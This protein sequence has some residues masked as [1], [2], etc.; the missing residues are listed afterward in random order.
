MAEP[1]PI[2]ADPISSDGSE[3]SWILLDEMD[4]AMN[5]E[6]N[7]S[8]YPT[9]GQPV[10]ITSADVL[11]DSNPV[12]VTAEE[13]VEMSTEETVDYPSSVETLSSEPISLCPSNDDDEDVDDVNDTADISR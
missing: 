3:E 8:Q 1:V 9:E 6:F 10:H 11:N 4:E 5:E 7:L 13:A 12:E 2:I